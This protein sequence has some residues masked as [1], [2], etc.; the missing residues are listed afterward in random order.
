[1]KKI[2]FV[3]IG[4][5]GMSGLALYCQFKKYKVSGCD[6]NLSNN[7]IKL[8][9]SKNITIYN[10]NLSFSEIIANQNI[11]VITNT[12][13]EK[14]PIYQEAVKQNKQIYLRSQFLKQILQNKKVIAITGSHGK[15][16]TTG[17][18]GDLLNKCNKKTNVFVGGIYKEYET[19]VILSKSHYIT[20]EADDAYKSFL[21]IYPFISIITSI[22]YEHLETYKNIEDIINNFYQFAIQTNRNGIII[23]NNDIN[24]NQLLIN[25]LKKEKYKNIVT[26]GTSEESDYQIKNIINKKKYNSFCIIHKNHII[27]KY[28]TPLH[29]IANIKNT[30]SVIIAAQFI[31]II[32]KKIKKNLCT[33]K[34]IERR[35]EYCGLSS[36]GIPI[37]DDYGH[38]PVEIEAVFSILQDNKQKA[39][40]FFQPHKYIRTKHLWADF[41]DVFLKNKDLIIKLFIT[42]IYE[43][44]EKYDEFYNSENLVNEIKKIFLD[45]YYIPFDNNFSQFKIYINNFIKSH[46]TIILT[47]GAGI[48]NNLASAISLR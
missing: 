25:K 35:F 43:I 16:T 11:I 28:K 26:Y 22:S 33:Y 44:N 45:T 34:G 21:D 42:D 37:Y 46:N 32:N 40:I 30:T 8:L 4:G 41:I 2:F 13:T 18:M 23:I 36:K 17:I 38:H 19:N 5:I 47:L 6:K 29:G 39:Y 10:E 1:M 48:L 24:Y 15:T 9:Q 7:T 14:H 20:V 3:G 27:G 12:I 31:K